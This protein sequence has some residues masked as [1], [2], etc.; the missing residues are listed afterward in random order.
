[1]VF[2]SLPL[3]FLLFNREK[4]LHQC[5]FSHNGRRVMASE[6]KLVGRLSADRATILNFWDCEG[7][8]AQKINCQ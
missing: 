4:I 6:E 7:R 8:L 1:M 2:N 3:S 5:S